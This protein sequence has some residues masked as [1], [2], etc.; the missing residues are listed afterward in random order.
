MLRDMLR[1]DGVMVGREMV[2]RLM[3][4]MGIKAVYLRLNTS[5]PAVGH[6][7]Y[8]YLLRKVSAIPSYRMCKQSAERGEL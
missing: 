7:I 2:A 4:S 1:A 8:P 3:R 6:K 5:K